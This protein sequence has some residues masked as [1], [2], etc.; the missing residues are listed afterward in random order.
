MQIH[1]IDTYAKQIKNAWDEK[2]FELKCMW[3]KLNPQV[4]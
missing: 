3:W 4:N 1:R 2:W